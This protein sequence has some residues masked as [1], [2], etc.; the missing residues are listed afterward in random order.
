MKPEEWEGEMGK[1][2][3]R[4]RER[5]NSDYPVLVI[6]CFVIQNSNS[7]MNMTDKN[8]TSYKH[9]IS[10]CLHQVT[11]IYWWLS[12]C[13]K[14]AAH[15]HGMTRYAKSSFKISS[16]NKIIAS[17]HNTKLETLELPCTRFKTD[18]QYII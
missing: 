18:R 11:C 16:Q 7:C 9:V 12:L 10:W 5:S 17:E 15:L 14:L 8:R 6:G 1:I 13:Y 4:E 2:G 3:K